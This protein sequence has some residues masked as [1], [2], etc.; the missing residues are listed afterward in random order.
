MAKKKPDLAELEVTLRDAFQKYRRR[1]DMLTKVK[2]LNM[3]TEELTQFID[4]MHNDDEDMAK[5]IMKI[6]SVRNG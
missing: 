6:A 1:L 4:A 2:G 5:R 3:S